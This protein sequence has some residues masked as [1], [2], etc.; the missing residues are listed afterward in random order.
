VGGGG[1]NASAARSAN[2]GGRRHAA[3]R[4]SSSRGTSRPIFG[5]PRRERWRRR[6]RQIMPEVIRELQQRGSKGGTVRLICVKG[7]AAC[8][9]AIARR[10]EAHNRAARW[11]RRRRDVAAQTPKRQ[12]PRSCPPCNLSPTHGQHLARPTASQTLSGE[13]GGERPGGAKQVPVSLVRSANLLPS[14]QLTQ[15]PRPLATDA[16]AAGGASSASKL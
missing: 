10:R 15:P 4:E 6:R 11:R 9:V 1:R 14:A 3:A 2:A 8:P 5:V 13:R 7:F 16:T 12:G